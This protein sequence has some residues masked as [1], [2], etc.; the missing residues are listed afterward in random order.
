MDTGCKYSVAS[1]NEYKIIIIKEHTHKM[2]KTPE[3]VCN[4]LVDSLLRLIQ[5]SVYERCSLT[6][7]CEN[8]F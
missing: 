3:T 5:G 7:S 1:G 6:V 4:D 2:N 8:T